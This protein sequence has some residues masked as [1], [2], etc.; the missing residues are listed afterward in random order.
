MAIRVLPALA[1][2]AACAPWPQWENCPDTD[3]ATTSTGDSTGDITTLMSGGGIQTVTGADESSTD[4]ELDTSST[5]LTEPAGPPAVVELKLTPDPI[6]FNGAIT[7]A[8]SAEHADGVRMELDSGEVIEL[9]MIEPGLFDGE[10]AVLTGLVNGAH[11]ALLTPW[12]DVVDGETVQAP[13]EVALPTPGSQ[14]FWETGDLIG[15]GQVAAMGVLP[16]GD[17]V[18]LGTFL[19][20]GES[21][22]Y[23][24]RRNKGGAWGPDDLVTILPDNNCAPIDLVIGDDGAMF[25]A[26]NRE[27]VDG[28]R[29]WLAKIPAWGQAPMN[30]GLGA[31]DETAVALSRH[32][33]GDVAVCGYAPSPWMDDDTMVRIFRPNL[34]GETLNF[35]FPL[36]QA[37]WFAERPRDCVYVDDTLA[38]V[39]EMYGPHGDDNKLR[40]RLFILNLDAE[41][42]AAWT[43]APSGDKTQSGAQAVDTDNE[44]RLV[45]AGYTCDDAC[46]PEGDLRIYDTR[47]ELAWQTSL[48][49]FPTKQFGT[50]HLLWSPAGYALVAT[51]GMKGNETAFTVRAFAPSKIEPVWTFARKDG[52]VLHLALALAIGHYGEVYAGGLGA[53]GY[54]AVAYIGG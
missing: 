9:A 4:V 17:V 42:Q 47:G 31:E 49:T 32:S 28:V 5:T 54:P 50:R 22:C 19:P 37:H 14:G 33:S 12:R 23:L 29:W 8:V 46:Q 51:G 40:D 52:Q 25:V 10:I 20:N 26:V 53:N 24:R 27:G 41:G 3:C 1:L 35:D 36:K 39:G 7:V 6:G 2:L 13:Y 21:R 48:G 16:T 43:V 45:I 11:V 18:E 15:G 30:L 34:P 44:G 38:L